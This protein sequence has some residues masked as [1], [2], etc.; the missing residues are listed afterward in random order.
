[1]KL[2]FIVALCAALLFGG[3]SSYTALTLEERNQK[4]PLDDE[5]ILIKLKD[6]SEIESGPYHHVEVTEPAGF[7]FGKGLRMHR[8]SGRSV[9]TGRL[10]FSSIDST[11]TVDVASG[12]YLHYWLPDTSLVSIEEKALI[13]VTP[14]S[15]TG[16]FCVGTRRNKEF[17][18]KVPFGDIE[19]IEVSQNS[20]SRTGLRTASNT[21][22]Y[23]AAIGLATAAVIVVLDLWNFSLFE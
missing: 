23:V 21:A 14:D 2:I 16:F 3:C 20:D 10:E 13:T 6:G 19:Q 7:V 4:R 12:R 15:G 5:T 17:R 11:R 1:M 9:F 8:S 18:G 22:L